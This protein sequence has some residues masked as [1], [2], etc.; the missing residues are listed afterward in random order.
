[1]SY[2]EI[3][4]VLLLV[5]VLGDFYFQSEKM[6]VKKEQNYNYVIVHSVIYALVGIIGMMIF[7]PGISFCYMFIYAISHYLVDSLKYYVKRRFN[8]N[9]SKINIFVLDQVIHLMILFVLGFQIVG[10]DIGYNEVITYIMETMGIS[11]SI[12]LKLLLVHKPINI[13][14]MAMMKSYKP[15]QKEDETM[16]TG[17]LI[18]TI[19]RIIM[20][21]FIII[22][23]YSSVGLVLTAKSIARYNKISESQEFA[24]YYLLGTLLST[25]SVLI[26]SII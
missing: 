26:V 23:Q 1:M 6:A 11:L 21:F 5:H 3:I 13:F 22:N 12:I 18:G 25:I 7:L 19:E 17:R 9:K 15:V 16:N 24:E 4:T 10:C 14:I 20:L 8:H 2:R